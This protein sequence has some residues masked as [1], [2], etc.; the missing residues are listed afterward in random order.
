MELTA[1]GVMVKAVMII[2]IVKLNFNSKNA[3]ITS[4]FFFAKLLLGKAYFNFPGVLGF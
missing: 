4:A 3:L 1:E 2:K